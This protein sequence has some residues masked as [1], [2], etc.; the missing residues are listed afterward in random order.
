MK[1][2]RENW[3]FSISDIRMS[4]IGNRNFDISLFENTKLSKIWN[5][6]NWIL[7]NTY[8]VL[9]WKKH[10]VPYSQILNWGI[11]NSNI[12]CS[13][14]E[15]IG[16]RFLDSE[17]SEIKNRNINM[18]VFEHIG[19]LDMLQNRKLE[20]SMF[21]IGKHRTYISRFRNVEIGNRNMDMFIFQ[22][23]IFMLDTF[24]VQTD[25][26]QSNEIC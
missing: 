7:G 1:I 26:N 9:N 16:H 11:E 15:N 8:G 5:V 20:D 2:K 13:L 12:W 14:L 19:F 23:I 10:G 6:A 18:F 25:T 24:I 22:H 21:L 3:G 17:M 4:K